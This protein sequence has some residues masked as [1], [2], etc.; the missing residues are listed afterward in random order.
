M[1]RP[2]G[3]ALATY[4]HDARPGIQGRAVFV[5]CRAP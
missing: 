3:Q 2:V 1:T 5:T 4:L